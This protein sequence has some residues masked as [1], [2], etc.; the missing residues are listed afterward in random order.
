MENIRHKK[1][2][3]LQDCCIVLDGNLVAKVV[4]FG[5]TKI[6][7]LVASMHI[8][9]RPCGNTCT[10]QMKMKRRKK[11]DPGRH[12]NMHTTTWSSKFKQWDPGII[13]ARNEFHN[14][15]NKV[16]FEG[17]GNV[18]IYLPALHVSFIPPIIRF[19]PYKKSKILKNIC[20]L[21]PGARRGLVWPVASVDWRQAQL[22]LV[23]RFLWKN[24]F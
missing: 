12:G 15:E 22:V 13:G 16:D 1:I 5:V 18:K 8:I 10:S 14:L 4:A 2:V 3:R 19:C 17:V 7:T 9:V 21:A 20:Q 11:W 6:V 24:M 23:W